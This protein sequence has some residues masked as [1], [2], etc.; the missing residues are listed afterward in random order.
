MIKLKRI[1]ESKKFIIDLSKV[2]GFDAIIPPYAVW[3]DLGRGK[4]EVLET[5]EDLDYLLMKHNLSIKDVHV[6][7]G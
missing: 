3:D 5:G 6:M 1:E 2:I 4:P 7:K